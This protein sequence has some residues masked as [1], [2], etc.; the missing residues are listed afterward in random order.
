MYFRYFGLFVRN[1]IQY[2][3]KKYLR[4]NRDSHHDIFY[5]A[6]NAIH[7]T[8]T[9]QRWDE[10]CNFRS[11][12]LLRSEKLLILNSILFFGVN[13]KL[14]Y[15]SFVS[16]RCERICLDDAICVNIFKFLFTAHNHYTRF[17]N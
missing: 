15:H 7:C 13:S 8:G 10:S 11:P 2:I 9:G 14:P 17:S 6:Q 1:I 12:N 4:I 3:T 16:N 5:I